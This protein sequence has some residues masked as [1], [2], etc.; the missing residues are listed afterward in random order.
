MNPMPIS[1]KVIGSFIAFIIILFAVLSYS[2]I[3]AMRAQP[4]PISELE[5]LAIRKAV[6]SLS[7]IIGTN[8]TEIKRLQDNRVRVYTQSSSGSGGDILELEKAEGV[9]SV[10][11]KGVWIP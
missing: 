2:L 11:K 6:A 8:V 9:W 3:S 7:D 4:K 10:R 1:K 5:Q